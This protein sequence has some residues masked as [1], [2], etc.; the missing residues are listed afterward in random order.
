MDRQN[1]S[2]IF[3]A[4]DKE[5]F[6]FIHHFKGKCLF[7]ESPP[8]IQALSFCHQCEVWVLYASSKHF[9]LALRLAHLVQ[10][11]GSHKIFLI[12]IQR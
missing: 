7:Y 9:T 4:A 11:T 12:L 3:M 6:N 5:S 2:L 8:S 10:K 1:T